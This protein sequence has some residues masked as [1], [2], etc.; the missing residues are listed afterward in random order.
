[1]PEH[2]KKKKKK[3]EDSLLSLAVHEPVAGVEHGEVV[4]VLDVA[5]LK[6]GVD[7]EPVAQE[8]QRVERLG[9]GL[10]D[11]RDRVAARQ[12]AEPDKVPPCVLE[13]DAFRRRRRGRLVEE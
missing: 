7:A 4:D 2:T 9:L 11:G 3:E 6:F 5:P 12:R 1:M 8:V 10:G 13:E